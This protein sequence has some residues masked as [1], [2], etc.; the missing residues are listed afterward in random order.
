VTPTPSPYWVVSADMGYG[1]QRAV[2]PFEQR[3]YNGVLDAANIPG[4][5]DAERKRWQRYLKLYEFLSRAKGLPLIGKQLFGLL[6]RML[7]IPSA[8]PMRNLSRS[9]FQ[10]DMLDKEIRRGLGS[11]V[12][13]TISSQWL[14]LLTSFY[15]PAI[16]ADLAGY[17]PIYTIICDADLNRVWV[18]K[19]PWES[20]INYFAPCGKAAQRL[21]QY[22]V[23][24]ERIFLTGFPLHEDLLGGRDLS[25]LRHD[26]GIRLRML[27]PL[28][29]FRATM[30]ASVERFLGEYAFGEPPANRVLTVTYA[31]GG[32]GAQRELGADLMRSFAPRLN[33]GT[34]RLVL[35]AGTRADV[36]DYFEEQRREILSP[37]ANV[38]VMH[39]PSLDAYFREFNAVIRETDILWTKPSELSFYTGLGLPIIMAPTI[40]SQEKFNRKW[41]REVGSGMRQENPNHATEWMFDLMANGRFADMAWLGFLRARKMGTYHIQDVIDQGT[42]T[43][44]DNPLHR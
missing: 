39:A 41:L 35:V 14:P 26:L 33:E 32:A 29:R 1:H 13:T 15:V 44:S 10:V 12:V 36:R 28:G 42:F 37:D 17:E 16:A 23:P 3:A 21:K 20:R 18:A 5:T 6:D 2:H 34:M 43:K 19:E 22:G 11:G 7:H 30:G 31:V 27:D 8:Y 38:H 4:V 25:V 9:T 24:E 40:G